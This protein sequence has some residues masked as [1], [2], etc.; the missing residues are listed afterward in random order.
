MLCLKRKPGTSLVIG[1]VTIH[2]GKNN[3][4]AV[5]APRDVPITRSELSE[6]D[7]LSR[8]DLTATSAQRK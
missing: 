6:R 5:D 4:I 2:F 3:S 8:R 7:D 1:E